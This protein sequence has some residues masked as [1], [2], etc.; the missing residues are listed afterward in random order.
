[1]LSKPDAGSRKSGDADMDQGEG[2]AVKSREEC[3]G[4]AVGGVPAHTEDD[5]CASGTQADQLNTGLKAL[6]ISNMDEP[7]K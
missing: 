4:G 3:S 7:I 1:M 6:E 2:R 5:V